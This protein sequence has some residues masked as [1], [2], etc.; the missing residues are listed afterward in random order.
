[1]K[2]D[3]LSCTLE[4]EFVNELVQDIHIA[5]GNH[6]SDQAAAALDPEPLTAMLD[7]T[8]DARPVSASLG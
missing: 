7:A 5:I 2:F 1:V 6:R 8:Q 4:V 3:R